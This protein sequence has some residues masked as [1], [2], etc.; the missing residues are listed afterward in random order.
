M[1]V[2]KVSTP[3]HGKLVSPGTEVRAYSVL[4]FKRSKSQTGRSLMRVHFTGSESIA[5]PGEVLMTFIGP[6]F[7]SSI[8]PLTMVILFREKYWL[9]AK[10]NRY[11]GPRRKWL[12][13]KVPWQLDLNK[14][15]RYTKILALQ[16]S[17]LATKPPSQPSYSTQYWAS[18][19]KIREEK[20][21]V[22]L[23]YE[24][25]EGSL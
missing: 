20:E 14:K 6:T 15:D 18:Y 19:D 5:H 2:Y 17:Y 9:R 22:W 7:T 1:K 8:H 12:G 3:P 21:L 11:F 23:L 10:R 13:Q 24:V 16:Q 4:G 25:K